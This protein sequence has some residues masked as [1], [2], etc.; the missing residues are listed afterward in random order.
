MCRTWADG[1]LLSLEAVYLENDFEIAGKDW[2]QEYAATD[3]AKR[4]F[5]KNCGT[6]LYWKKNSGEC[7]FNAGLFDDS[8]FKLV[9]EYDTNQKPAYLTNKIEE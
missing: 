5:C 9:A 7:F 6:S 1:A 4:G 2:I 8:D 3:V